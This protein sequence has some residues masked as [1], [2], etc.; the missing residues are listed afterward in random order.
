[1]NLDLRHLGKKKLRERL[2]QICE[3]AE[4]FLGI[5]PAEKP[6]PVRPAVHYT[7]GGILVNGDTASTLTGLYAVGECSSI[8][9]HGANRLGSNSLAELSVFGKVAGEAAARCARS[10]QPEPLATLDQQ[11]EDA[12][13]RAVDLVRSEAGSERLSVLRDAMAASMEQ[14]CGIFRDGAQMQQTCDTL[15]ELKQ[16]FRRLRLDDTSRAWNTE[17]LAAIELGYQ[18]DVAEAM[19]HSARNRKESRG[20]HSRIDG[21]E[22][23]D[24]ANFLKHTLATYRADGPPAISYSPVNITKSAPGKRAY[25]AAGERAEERRHAK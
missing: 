25:G 2:P 23:R 12:R 16:R 15:A 7:M 11:A 20:A 8:G 18:L 9:I 19:A 21:F 5:D 14:G 13:R 17:W 6:I 10:F 24:D 1:V 22:Q 3:L 4:S